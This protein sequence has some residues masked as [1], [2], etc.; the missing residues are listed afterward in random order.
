LPID[1]PLSLNTSVTNP[2]TFVPGITVSNGT[3]EPNDTKS[4]LP[5]PIPEATEFYNR[6]EEERARDAYMRALRSVMS[7]LRDMNDLG[8]SQSNSMSMYGGPG[9]DI[10]IPRSRRPTDAATREPSLALSPSASMSMLDTSQ[11]RS[12]ETM[13]GLRSGSSSQTISVMTT[14]STFCEEKKCKDDKGKRAMVVREIVE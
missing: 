6:K 3:D 9:E 1:I 11:L 10:V 14:D 13:S 12:P 8:L 7:Y 2:A 4:A 5:S